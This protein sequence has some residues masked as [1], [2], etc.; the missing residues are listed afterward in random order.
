MRAKFGWN[1]TNGIAKNNNRL[2]NTHSVNDECWQ[3]HVDKTWTRRIID[4]TYL[5][6]WQTSTGWNSK[7]AILNCLYIK[8]IAVKHAYDD[9]QLIC[10]SLC[11]YAWVCVCRMFQQAWKRGKML[12]R[13][14][15]IDSRHLTHEQGK[16]TL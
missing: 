2:H 1:H 3:S 7:T 16:F 11:L 10:F 4:K 6:E 15:D 9:S 8:Y 13:V 14:C 12:M 5:M